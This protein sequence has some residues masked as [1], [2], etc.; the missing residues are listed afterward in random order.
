MIWYDYDFFFLQGGYINIRENFNKGIRA[1][2][3]FQ[4]QGPVIDTSFGV[5]EEG[6]V[7]IPPASATLESDAPFADSDD[8][9][10]FDTWGDDSEED[11]DWDDF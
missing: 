2:K 10:N 7:T 1:K 11:D 9:F 5:G 4:R 6:I 3:F 8:D